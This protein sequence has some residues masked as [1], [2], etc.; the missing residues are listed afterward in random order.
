M[1]KFGPLSTTDCGSIHFSSMFI[2]AHARAAGRHGDPGLRDAPRQPCTGP[3]TRGA[4]PT[5]SSLSAELVSDSQPSEAALAL[6]QNPSHGVRLSVAVG[7]LF[8]VV[9]VAALVHLRT[10]AHTVNI[11]KVDATQVLGLFWPFR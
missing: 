7:R 5:L 11:T 6:Q 3:L 1:G 9:I 8:R 10:L 2:A 4:Q